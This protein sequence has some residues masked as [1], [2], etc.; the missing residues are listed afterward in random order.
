MNALS[1][2]LP[3]P[4]PAA[5][6][7]SNQDPVELA[8]LDRLLGQDTAAVLQDLTV[9]ELLAAMRG[10]AP[11]PPTR[12]TMTEVLSRR[13]RQVVL[14]VAEG[15]SNKEISSR[16]MLSDKTVKNHVSHILAKLNLS[17]RTQ[18]AIMALRAGVV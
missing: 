5:A 4:Q 15:L 14:L 9:G 12:P 16:L 13:E 3:E 2:S 1:I 17:A 10:E 7:L 18:I 6:F 8:A 11:A